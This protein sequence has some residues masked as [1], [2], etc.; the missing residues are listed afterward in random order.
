MSGG[1]KDDHAK[2]RTDLLPPDAL[3]AVAEVLT[4]GAERYGVRNWELGMGWGRVCAALLR[5]VF[6]WMG[7]QEHDPETGLLHLAHAACCVL[8]L[9]SYQMREIG[10]DDRFVA[11]VKSAEAIRAKRY[12]DRKRGLG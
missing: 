5:H 12:R 3:M 6:A 8:F 7:G 2:K 10:T 11:T 1:R 9:L 4:V